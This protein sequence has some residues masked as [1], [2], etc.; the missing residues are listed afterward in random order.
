MKQYWIF[1]SKFA[2]L[3]ENM[4]NTSE[5]SYKLSIRF[6]SDGFSLEICDEQDLKLSSKKVSAAM[7]TLSSS[8]IVKILQEELQFNYKEVKI[9]L[10]SDPYIFVP[11]EIFKPDEAAHFIHFQHKTK[12]NERV[13]FNTISKWD[14]VNVFTIA[15]N[16]QQAIEEVFQNQSIEHHMSWFLSHQ[17]ILAQNDSLQIWARKKMAD[18]VAI[19]H[20]QLQ[21]LN[22]YRY[23]T[24]EDFTYHTLNV[25]EQLLLD[26]DKCKVYLHNAETVSGLEKLLNNYVTVVSC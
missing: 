10:E 25:M 15:S 5:N 11:T 12:K 2:V 4:E 24:A 3:Y 23:Q 14:T 6:S 22:S 26:D 8:E 17:I 1:F 21:L 18:I 20:G 19:K 7:F 9:I 13:I 16:L